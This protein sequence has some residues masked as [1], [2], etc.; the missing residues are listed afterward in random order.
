ALASIAFIRQNRAG[1]VFIESTRAGEATVVSAYSPRVRLTPGDFTP[2][3]PR[4]R[5][6]P[7]L[8]SGPT[9]YPTRP[10]GCRKTLREEATPLR[11]L[12]G[13][14]GR[15][16]CRG[17]VHHAEWSHPGG[18]TLSRKFFACATA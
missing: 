11:S 18:R 7:S 6:S 4:R 10:E 1:K 5:W 8:I 9:G 2:H 12:T 14:S 3:T 15:G 13:A 17:K 16:A